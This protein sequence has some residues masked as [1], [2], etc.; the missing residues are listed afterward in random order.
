MTSLQSLLSS[1]HYDAKEAA[2][3]DAFGHLAPTTGDHNIS[4]VFTYTEFGNQEIISTKHDTLENSPWLYE[5]L[6]DVVFNL[7]KEHNLKEGSVF[8]F[9]GVFSFG[10]NKD[11]AKEQII[12]HFE[13]FK[14]EHNKNLCDNDFILF[15][16]KMKSSDIKTILENNT[17]DD[18]V[19]ALPED[20]QSFIKEY[21]TVSLLSSNGEIS[22]LI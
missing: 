11:I 2:I 5:N 20:R 16:E 18:I 22:R 9:N 6:K 19:N 12:Q 10:Y 4:F 17:L 15:T 3:V 8:S 1:L 21:F 7:I 13:D 14:F